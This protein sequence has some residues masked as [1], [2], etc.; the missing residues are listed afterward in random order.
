MI[1]PS[2]FSLQAHIWLDFFCSNL[3]FPM[4]LNRFCTDPLCQDVFC[5][6]CLF[7]FEVLTRNYQLLIF[8]LVVLMQTQVQAQQRAAALAGL[9]NPRPSADWIYP[10]PVVASTNPNLL[11]VVRPQGAFETVRWHL[12]QV[13]LLHH[14][15]VLV[16][17]LILFQMAF[18]KIWRGTWWYIPLLDL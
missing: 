1:L 2:L 5:F 16:V 15:C 4:H 18:N 7:G 17:K 12:S 10:S 3:F 13:L 8:E 9:Q 11:P 6:V 14:Y